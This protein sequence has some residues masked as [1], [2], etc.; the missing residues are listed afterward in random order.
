MKKLLMFV[1]VATMFL[2]TINGVNAQD[3]KMKVGIKAGLNIANLTG[4]DTYETKM[5]INIGATFEY[6]VIP[7]LGIEPGLFYSQQGSFIPEDKVKVQQES[8]LNL[9]YFNV[10]IAIK[11]YPVEFVSIGLVPQLGFN[12]GAKSVTEALDLGGGNKEE[13][14]TID[15]KEGTNSIDFGLGFDVAGHYK[16]FELG[17]RY[18]LGLTDIRKDNKGDAISN[19]VMTISL[20]YNLPL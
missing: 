4:N 20:G 18:N 11:Y 5:G 16:G 9:N 2:G 6:K 8:S 15:L 19:R 13:G 1:A 12:I 14:G 7:N 3:K 10:P 17:F